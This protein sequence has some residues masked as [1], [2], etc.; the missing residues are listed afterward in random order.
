[1][2]AA[3]ARIQKAGADKPKKSTFMRTVTKQKSLL[4]MSLPVI[5]YVFT[6]SYRPLKGLVMAFQNYRPGR[7]V[8]Q[9]VGFLQFERLFTDEAFFRILRNT[10]CMS[11]INLVTGLMFA[12]MLAVLINEIRIKPFKRVAQ[13][14]S[15]MPHFLSWI[16]VTGIIANFLASDIGI[17]NVTLTKLGILKKNIQWLGEPDLFWGIVAGSNLWKE[18]GW[19]SIIFLAAITSIS[20]EQYEA[21]HM[22]GANRWQ[23]ILHITLAG[24]RPTIV[25]LLILNLGWI[26]NGGGF[27]VQYLLGNNGMVSDVSTTIDIFVLRNGIRLANYSLGTAAGLFKSVV[28]LVILTAANSIANRLGEEKLL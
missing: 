10:I 27:E 17:V 18:T 12:I 22:D 20:P 15:Y 28:S 8:Q 24:I 6:F 21:A 4:L 9:W 16:I 2:A 1:M 26:L 14:I 23:K 7:D 19:N 3:D 25:V 5:V 11:L 13:C